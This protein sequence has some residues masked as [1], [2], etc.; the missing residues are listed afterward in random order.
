MNGFH[1]QIRFY[2]CKAIFTAVPALLLASDRGQGREAVG[3]V[4]GDRACFDLRCDSE[5]SS[6]I[7]RVNVGYSGTG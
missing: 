5:S 6:E 2:S 7:I 3:R 4:D 1:F